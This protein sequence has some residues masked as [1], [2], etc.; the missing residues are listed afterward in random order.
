[1]IICPKHLT[2]KRKAKKVIVPV[3]KI[4][5]KPEKQRVKL[6]RYADFD[7]PIP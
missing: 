7:F 5:K 6:M 4:V 1:M 2:I 3:K